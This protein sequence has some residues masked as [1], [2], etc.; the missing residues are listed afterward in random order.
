M[1]DGACAE[2]NQ[3]CKIW[4][5]E[6]SPNGRWSAGRSTNS[7][8]PV[9]IFSGCCNQRVGATLS[10][11][12]THDRL[13]TVLLISAALAAFVFVFSIILLPPA[14]SLVAMLH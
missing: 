9:I 11:A 2:D 10:H 3:K 1:P 12:M 5:I 13:N 7:A 4:R 6:T 8:M 14:S